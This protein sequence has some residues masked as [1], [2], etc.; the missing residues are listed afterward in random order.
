[1]IDI[2]NIEP[3]RNNFYEISEIESLADDIERQGL[4]NALVVSEDDGSFPM[5]FRPQTCERF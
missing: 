1:M 4:M 5:T 2:D 3:N